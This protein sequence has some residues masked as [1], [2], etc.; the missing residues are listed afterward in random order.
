[1]AAETRQKTREGFIVSDK[2][3]KTVVVK[4][5]RMFQHPVYKRTVKRSKKYKAHDPQNDCRMGDRVRIEETRPLSKQKHWRVIE[6]IE[7]AKSVSA[8]KPQ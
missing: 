7:R 8:G 6:V 5:E 4:V 3:D 1:M 2:M